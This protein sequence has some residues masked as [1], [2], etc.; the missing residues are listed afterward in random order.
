MTAPTPTP[1]KRLSEE[2]K[3]ELYALAGKATPGR[4]QVR[5]SKR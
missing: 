2:R 5:V 4:W 3:A 1:E